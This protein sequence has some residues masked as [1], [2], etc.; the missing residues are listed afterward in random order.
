M[1]RLHDRHDDDD[2][3]NND[4]HANDEAHLWNANQI[5]DS[6]TGAYGNSLSCLST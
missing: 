4:S 3:D 2:D 5:T 1:R 6:E